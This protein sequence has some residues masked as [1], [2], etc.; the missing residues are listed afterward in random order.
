MRSSVHFL[1]RPTPAILAILWAFVAA[2]TPR[3]VAAQSDRPAAA[4]AFERVT[5]IPMTGDTILPN[6]TVIVQGG[7]ITTV[8]PTGRVRVPNGARRIDGRGKFLFPG[9][10]D[11]HVHLDL[12]PEQWMGWL[13]AHGVTTV[14]NL[15]G[16]D[17]HLS[18]AA[19]IARGEVIGPTVYT[20]GPYTNAPA[21]ATPA[22]AERAVR[23]QKAA[24]YH[25][26]KVHGNL[27]AESYA[28]LLEAGRVHGIPVIG[29]APRNLAFDSVIAGRH[30]MV[31]HAEE[32]I[33]TRFRTLDTLEVPEVA[34][35]MAAAGIWLTPTL[36]TFRGIARQWSLPATIDTVLAD[37]DPSRL[38]EALRA[39]W[40]SR[41]PYTG[42]PS[43]RERIEQAYRFQLPMVGT[44]HR[45]GVPL[46][47]GTDTPL[48][49]M[50]PGRSLLDEMG[51]LELAGLSRREA[52]AA[53][54]VNPGRFVR[55]FVDS[56]ARFGIIAEGFR[57]DLLLL[58][59]SPL[60]SLATLARPVGV[61]AAG[62][63][64]DNVAALTQ[65]L[66]N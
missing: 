12:S 60:E 16:S 2:G 7:T 35:R 25:F 31:A 19:Q 42:R 40:R 37:G 30:P 21:I 64:F 28:A 66:P 49:I 32:L 3:R 27:T 63:W 33:Y 65:S 17:R 6:H 4:T 15:R 38:T 41:N 18:L 53:A 23:E 46:L 29:H 9:L 52:L 58:D 43:G 11:T 39:Y 55:Q 50:V 51:E 8:G 59:A 44:L 54:T 10:T 56:T 36:T 5:V 57:A 34:A 48:P 26:V 45:A 24:G 62:R 1:F 14:F 47:T 22:D 61:M 13:L 20:S